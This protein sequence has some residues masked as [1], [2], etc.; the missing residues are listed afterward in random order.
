MTCLEELRP[1]EVHLA[2]LRIG[3]ARQDPDAAAN[4]GHVLAQYTLGDI[5]ENAWAMNLPDM[6]NALAESVKWY[7]MAAEHALTHWRYR[8]GIRADS[9]DQELDQVLEL[10]WCTP[11]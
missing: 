9:T 6:D 1:E 8:T 4:N 10:D 11:V 2:K 7:R 3:A 5:Y